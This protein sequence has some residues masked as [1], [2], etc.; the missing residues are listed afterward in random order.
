MDF[1]THNFQATVICSPLAVKIHNMIVD[2]MKK[3]NVEFCG[4]LLAVLKLSTIKSCA[5]FFT[6]QY[7]LPHMGA[8]QKI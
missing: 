8:Q 3:C 7:I 4:N 2:M 6:T 1:W 5:I